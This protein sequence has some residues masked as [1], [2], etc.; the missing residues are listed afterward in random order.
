MSRL[1]A[2]ADDRLSQNDVGTRWHRRF[3]GVLTAACAVLVIGGCTRQYIVSD[4][5]P[6][7]YYQTAFPIRDTSIDLA[8]I[9]ASIH[10][11]GVSS[12]YTTYRFG[13]EDSVR[14]AD[15][16]N[17]ATLA[18]AREQFTFDHSK[19]GT[20]T[21]V[22]ASA[23]GVTLI[24]NDHVTRTPDTVFVYFG[25]LPHAGPGAG[26]REFVESVS[27]RTRQTNFV[28]GLPDAPTFRIVARDSA[29]DLALI[30]VNLPGADRN[31]RIQVLRVPMGD[32]SRLT[33]G[34][35]VYVLGYPRGYRMVTRGIVSDPGYADHDAFLL[36]GLFNRGIS[37]GLILAVRGTTG[38]LEW[39]GIA[40][41]AA[42][43]SEFRLVPEPRGTQ[44]DGLL[45][46]YDG[47]LYIQRESR[48]EYGITFPVS[49][50]AIR[51]FLQSARVE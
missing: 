32:A 22:G 4:T 28:P 40:S 33:W 12:T 16:G 35:F 45:V 44:E 23:A 21:V 46:P 36:D 13:R 27:I 38:A 3:H 6:Q 48:I 8:R 19:A 39:V 20:A 49:M 2:R 18:R 1:H 9:A 10:R 41:S 5:G 29:N 37:G 43:Q 7:A 17:P 24:T 31:S 11:I 47:S 25:D 42:A 50:T 30:R 15:I 14:V 34:S 26:S 51:R